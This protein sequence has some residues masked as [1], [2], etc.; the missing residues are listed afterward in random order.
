M[1]RMMKVGCCPSNI[2]VRSLLIGQLFLATLSW[3]LIGQLFLALDFIL[4]FETCL[5]LSYLEMDVSKRVFQGAIQVLIG[6][7]SPSLVIVIHGHT[8]I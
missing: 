7:F 3:L 8:S 2:A 5:N 4:A 6:S 1:I